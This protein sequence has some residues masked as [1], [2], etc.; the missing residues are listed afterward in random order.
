LKQAAEEAYLKHN[1]AVAAELR[2]RGLYPEGDINTFLRAG[3]R[4]SDE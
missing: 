2:A 4:D 1:R 3:G